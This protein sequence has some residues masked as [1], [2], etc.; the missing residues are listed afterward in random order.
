[1]QE[2]LKLRP[3]GRVYVGLVVLLGVATLAHSARAIYLHPI[4]SQWFVLAGLTLLTGSFTVKVPSTNASL[5][6]SETFVFA[7]VLYFGP[8]SGA[9]TVLLECVVILLWMKP[10]GRPLHQI[11]FNTA[12]PAI[13]IW[14]S[15]TTF[16]L[17]S[18]KQPYSWAD[19]VN[20]PVRP[21]VPLLPLVVFTALYFFLNSWLVAL[22]L[23]FE[24]KKPSFQIWWKNFAWLSVNYFSGASVAALLVIYVQQFDFRT[25]AVIVPLLVVSY[26]TFRTAMGRVEDASHHL[27][28]LNRLYLSTIETLAMAIDAKD[29][30]THGHIR[31]VQTY[32]NA[33]AR[34]MG[35]SDERLI[36]AIEAAALLH[37]MGKLA[38]PEYILNKPGKLTSAEFEKMKLHASVGADILLAIDFPYPVV[39]IVRH[40]HENWDGSGY[41]TGLRGTDIPIG[42]RI[43]SVVDCFDALTSD[44]PYRPRL[45]DSQALEILMQRRGTM[46]DPLVVDTFIRVHDSVAAEPLAS[47]P[48]P[49]HALAEF[50]GARKA[51]PSTATPPVLD[52]IVASADETLTLYAL[53]R[54]LGGQSNAADAANLVAKHVRRLI[55]F[56]LFVLFV[57]DERTAEL[58][59]RHVVGDTITLVKGLRVP[60]GERLSGWVGAN[61]QTILNSDP[62]LDFGDVARHHAL[63]LKSCI[64][65]PLLVDDELVGVLSLYSSEAAAFNEDHRRVVEAVARQAAQVVSKGNV[66]DQSVT[67]DPLRSLPNLDQLAQ[68]FLAD[69]KGHSENALLFITFENMATLLSVFDDKPRH[70]FL[71]DVLE[72][73]R[74]ELRKSDIL[75]YDG[76]NVFVALLSSSHALVANT[77]AT[78]IRNALARKPI[79]TQNGTVLRLAVDVTVVSAPIDVRLVSQ[80]TGRNR[81]ELTLGRKATKEPLVH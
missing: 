10:R 36:K 56:S 54:E 76:G 35:I 13:A 25:L 79:S 68:I 46:Y 51:L 64:S 53:A 19:H 42:A 17:I 63:G 65:T 38:V 81:A 48:P 39:P 29:Q 26:L 61:R 28:E 66:F 16:F 80:I 70:A 11:L 15:G 37:D 62:V 30:V 77:T 55:P 47:A 34:E 58:E 1:M 73:I 6:V 9:I 8:E 2:F 50:A 45:S 7:S 21:T 44:R 57:V 32:A 22:A 60:L 33:L 67:R 52:E 4:G 49:H 41:P 3:L 78:N 18:G 20:D 72:V 5:S 43:L 74:R 23:S 75:F 59:A 24:T 27:T 69:S 40:H 12:A 14:V 31:R 71:G